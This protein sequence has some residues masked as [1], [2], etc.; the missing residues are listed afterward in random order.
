MQHIVPGPLGTWVPGDAR[1]L[2]NGPIGIFIAGSHI[3]GMN[4]CGVSKRWLTWRRT[5]EM[6]CAASQPSTK[7]GIW[8]KPECCIYKQSFFF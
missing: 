4:C 2:H 5:A 3:F 8:T 7:I 1:G 6:G